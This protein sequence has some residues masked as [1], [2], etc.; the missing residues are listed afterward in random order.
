MTQVQFNESLAREIT[1]G[2]T[3][4]KIKTRDG[5][6]VRLLAFD[7]KNRYCIAGV[8]SLNGHDGGDEYVRQ[9]TKEGKA[10]FRS[11]VTSN[12]DL[13]IEVEGGEA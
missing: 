1:G 10:D 13:V 6:P 7:I 5:M 3:L 11:Y 8:V 2:V 9:W 12:Y 4:G